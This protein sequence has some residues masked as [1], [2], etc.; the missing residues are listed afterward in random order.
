MEPWG[1]FALSLLI[2][3]GIGGVWARNRRCVYGRRMVHGPCQQRDDRRRAKR[4]VT[5]FGRISSTCGWLQGPGGWLVIIHSVIMVAENMHG[6]FLF[7]IDVGFD[8][9]TI[10]QSFVTDI[11][12]TIKGRISEYADP[13]PYRLRSHCHNLYCNDMFNSLRMSSNGQKLADISKPRKC[14]RHIFSSWETV[15]LTIR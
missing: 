13:N 10:I 3:M 1:F 11:Y 5:W 8:S 14:V 2:N 6:H 4:V 15:P 12:P 9:I 7:S